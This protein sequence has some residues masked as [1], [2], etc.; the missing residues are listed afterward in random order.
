[1]YDSRRKAMEHH[2]KRVERW[3]KRCV[4]A[5]KCGSWDEAL[6]EADCLEAETKGLREKLWSAMTEERSGTRTRG[7]GAAIFFRTFKAAVLSLVIVM[8]AVI[9]LSVDPEAKPEVSLSPPLMSSVALLTSAESDIINALRESLSSANNGRVVLMVEI[10]EK[11][12]AD[13]AP[14]G[15]AMASE[16]DAEAPGPEPVHP[17][18]DEVISLIQVGQR[19]LRAPD[20]AIKIIP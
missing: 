18:A 15:A 6:V 7:V 2:L 3:F 19:V 17:S 14:R 12:P 20:S 8:A 5:C 11:S 4:A 1:M 16:A 9:P 10:P 13:V